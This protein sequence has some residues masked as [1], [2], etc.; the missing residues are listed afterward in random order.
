MSSTGSPRII[1]RIGPQND[2]KHFDEYLERLP[3]TLGRAET[4]LKNNIPHLC[5]GKDELTISRK[6]AKIFWD[7]AEKAYKILCWSKNCCRVDGKRLAVDEVAILRTKSTLRL[8]TAKFYFLYPTPKA[9]TVKESVQ[10]MSPSYAEL[11]DTAYMSAELGSIEL[12]VTQRAVVQWIVKNYP[13]YGEDSKKNNLAQGIYMALNKNYE[14]VPQPPNEKSKALRW[15]RRVKPAKET[16]NIKQ[17]ETNTSNHNSNESSE[18][19]KK[20]RVV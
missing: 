5:I 20:Q 2:Y 4:N 9:T 3:L 11:L 17:S 6:H 18:T 10:K 12:G 13:S 15:R 7:D 16:Q 14:R 1:G 8:G 19:R